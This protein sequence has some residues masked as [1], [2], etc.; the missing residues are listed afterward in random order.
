MDSLGIEL[1]SHSSLSS[2]SSTLTL[3][4]ALLNDIILYLASAIAIVSVLK[5]VVYVINGFTEKSYMGARLVG[6]SS[7]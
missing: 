5:F 2:F 4:H 6:H 7:L 3:F 1:P